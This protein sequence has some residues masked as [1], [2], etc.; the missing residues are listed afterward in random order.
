MLLKEHQ[1]LKT[2]IIEIPQKEKDKLLLRLIA[3]DK[4]LT[5]HLHFKLLENEADL[6]SRSRQ[7][8][9]EI[10]EAAVQLEQDLKPSSKETLTRLRKL[11]GRVNHHYKV[12]R[13]V[14][15]EAELRIYL[16]KQIPLAF[17]ES[18]FSSMYKF[19]EKLAAYFLRTTV[20]VLNKYVKLHEDWQFDLKE[21]LNA[22]LNKIFTGKMA[23]A[24]Q[25]LDLPKEV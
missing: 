22:V 3:K 12:T 2:A 5:E 24:A 9:D 11:N 16:L 23:A 21:D 10:D 19:Q 25:Q 15:S 14:N 20:S 17:N 8:K 18:L 6:D 4:V 7:L 13:D 1:E